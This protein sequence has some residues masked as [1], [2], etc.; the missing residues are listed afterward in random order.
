MVRRISGVPPIVWRIVSRLAETRPAI[1]GGASNAATPEKRL[2]RYSMQRFRTSV[3]EAEIAPCN[4][5]AWSGAGIGW[6]RLAK[7]A[8]LPIATKAKATWTTLLRI[9]R[10]SGQVIRP[11]IRSGPD[12]RRSE[13]RK[14]RNRAGR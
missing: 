5:P 6:A 11:T 12:G 3:I 8:Q 4:R 9:R 1:T 13:R 7:A 2:A 14:Q 10:A